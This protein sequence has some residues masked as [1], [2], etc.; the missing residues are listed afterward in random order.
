MRVIEANLPSLGAYDVRF[1]KESKEVID[2]LGEKEFERLDNINHLGIAS[3]VFTGVNHS[4]LEYVLLQCALIQLLPRF[5]KGKEG[6]SLSGKVSIPGQKSKIS[7]CEELLKCWV[8][9]SN[10][11]H[12]QYTYGVERSLLNKA[13]EDSD[14]L[15]L[16]VSDLPAD[17][18]KYS[19]SIIEDYKDSQFH[20]IL[21]LRR[22]AKLPVGSR[23][24]GRLFRLMNVLML[25]LDDMKITQPDEKYKIYRIKVLYER[26][27]LLSIV[28][29][30]SYYSH[31]PMRYDVSSALMNLDT[32]FSDSLSRPGFIG[33]LRQT[34]SWL[35]DELYMH[36]KAASAQ[37]MYEVV[38]NRKLNGIYKKHISTSQDFEDFLPNFMNNGFGKPS[39]EN[40]MHFSRM[41][42]IYRRTGAWF[43][44][45]LFDLNLILERQI[46]PSKKDHVSVLVN[47]Y[48]NVLH[49]DL[50][51]DC[52]LSSPKSIGV[53]CTRTMGWLLRLV[54][55]Q[56]KY[57][58]RQYPLVSRNKEFENKIRAYYTPKIVDDSY[59]SLAS[60]FNGVINY[61]LP[62]G[63]RGDFTEFVSEEPKPLGIKLNLVNGD[64]Y[65]PLS[66]ILKDIV[67]YNKD[68]L[69]ADRIHEIKTIQK[70]VSRSKAN[71]I[72]CGVEK[73]LV[74]S[75]DSEDADDW[76]GVI[77]EIFDNGATLTIIEAKNLK[78]KPSSESKGFKQL[79]DTQD[80]IKGR[81]K[82]ITT[83]RRRIKGCGAFLRIE[84][85]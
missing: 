24:K 3:Y 13:C 74:R 84:L 32:L 79:K 53:L 50:L 16:L 14:F 29:L 51:Y 41:S 45:N 12:A 22:I 1:H 48:S 73:F 37:K 47:P 34:S 63:M 75:R 23:L 5:H 11:G 68:N 65:D 2:F 9:L 26:I 44:K 56:L 57:R 58:I 67:G 76:D 18:K 55:A 81:H 52:N 43:G 71:A 4:R 49:I 25:G 10:S 39:L 69:G 72:I 28:S 42:F 30:D 7:S 70:M 77:L 64:T 36:P 60:L 78:S 40:L 35:A 66:E 85:R 8:I 38:S 21:T 27:R 61:F 20:L 33:L 6:L 80:I 82:R 19:I 46:S 54:E 83:R 17:L 31:N 59:Y 62:D 15:D